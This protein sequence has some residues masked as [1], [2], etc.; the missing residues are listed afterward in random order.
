MGASAEAPAER[1]RRP[2]SRRPEQGRSVDLDN[3]VRPVLAGLRD[4]GVFARGFPGLVALGASK[5]SSADTGVTIHL[6]APVGW[7]PEAHRASGLLDVVSSVVPTDG[8][9]DSKRAWREAVATA[10]TVEPVAHEV[11]VSA[12]LRTTRSLEGLMKPIIDGLEPILGRDPRGRLEFV[13][14]DHLV[15]WLTFRKDVNSES[16]LRVRVGR[17]SG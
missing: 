13:P 10:W 4:A 1:V 12:V 6:D 14:N 16:A 9:V 3:L 2:V 17:A 11:W 8:D 5:V 7:L 15:T